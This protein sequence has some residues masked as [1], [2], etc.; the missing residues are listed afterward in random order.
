MTKTTLKDLVYKVNGAAIEVH[1]ELGSGLLESTYHKC[2]KRELT[3]RKIE[4]ISEYDVSLDYK[5]EKVG[6]E[7]RCDLFVENMLPVELKSVEAFHPIHDAQLL[8]YMKLMKA[9]L[10]LLINFNSLSIFKH[11]Q[12]TLVNEL[13]RKLLE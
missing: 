12:K 9:P 6:A 7:L 8:T 5:G 4:F 13:Y 10:G 1:R 2:M 11:G 3:L